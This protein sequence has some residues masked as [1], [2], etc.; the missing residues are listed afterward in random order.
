ML[1]RDKS[2]VCRR[3]FSQLFVP[4]IVKIPKALQKKKGFSEFLLQ[5]KLAICRLSEFTNKNHLSSLSHSSVLHV[6]RTRRACVRPLHRALWES[7]CYSE[8]T[9]FQVLSL[10]WVACIYTFVPRHTR[11]T[12]SV[13]HVRRTRRACVSPLH[14]S[15][16][17]SSCY[18]SN[19][20]DCVCF[21]TAGP[22]TKLFAWGL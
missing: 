7:S 22:I 15:L 19:L 6:R 3:K 17:E 14:R 2:Q 10:I 5:F 1:R 8:Q 12:S 9:H 13:I 4:T 21:I 16:W 20:C 18:S 11:V